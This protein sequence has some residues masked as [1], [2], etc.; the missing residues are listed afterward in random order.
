MLQEFKLKYCSFEIGCMS[1][2]HG[3]PNV[4]IVRTLLHQ[5][6]ITPY[7]DKTRSGPVLGQIGN[8]ICKMLDIFDF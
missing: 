7:I 4:G 2:W 8:S 5:V 3:P 1:G 6:V